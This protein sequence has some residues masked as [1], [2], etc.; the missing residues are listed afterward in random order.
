M[1]FAFRERDISIHALREEGDALTRCERLGKGI[2]IHALREEGDGPAASRFFRWRKFLST[3]SARR[4]TLLQSVQPAKVRDFYPRPPRGG[5]L[6]CGQTSA[7]G[8]TN[9]YPRPPRGG[10]RRDGDVSAKA[11]LFLSTPSA[12][13]ATGVKGLQQGTRL[14]SIHALREEGDLPAG[15]PSRSPLRFLST[16]SARRATR[17]SGGGFFC[18]LNFYPRPPRGG[19]RGLAYHRNVRIGHF[20]PRPPRGGRRSGWAQFVLC[21]AISIHALREEGD[22][23]CCWV[24]PATDLFLSTPSARRATASHLA[25]VARKGISIHALREEGDVGV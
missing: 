23:F 12:R 13:R 5:R 9:F 25:G 11:H 18:F 21:M 16:P 4:A 7:L 17:Q 24:Y 3:P 15:T 2:S 19:R 22:C 14:I 8:A 20:Y 10:R 1:S 6:A